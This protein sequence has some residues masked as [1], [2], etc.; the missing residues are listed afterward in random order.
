MGVPVS[1]PL[2]VLRTPIV[3]MAP[4]PMF[5]ARLRR[6]IERLLDQ[7]G[8]DQSEEQSE[9]ESNMADVLHRNRLSRNGTRHGDVSYITL[10]V[11]DAAAGRRFYGRLL[12]WNFG[13]GQLESEGR[14]VDEV[15][16]QVGLWPAPAWRAWTTPGAILSWRVDDIVAAVGA[17]RAAGGTASEPEQLPYGLQSECDDGSGLHFWLHEL[18][19]PGQPA[20]ANGERHGDISYIVLQVADLEHARGFFSRIAGWEYSPGS[21]GVQVEGTTPMTGMSQGSPGVVLCYRVDDIAE[22]VDRVAAAG[23]SAG[24]V[25]SRPYGLQSLCVDDQGLEFYLHQF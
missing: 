9:E 16:P 5:A 14:Q 4:D 3:P 22:A 15:I 11:P 10:A 7:S 19:G 8:E 13:P 20:G 23:G 21:S 2:D 1:D 12:G 25:E 24:P 18:P 6:R 17:V